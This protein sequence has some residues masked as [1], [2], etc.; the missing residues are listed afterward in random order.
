LLYPDG[1]P[2]F[3]IPV[4]YPPSK[5]IQSERKTIKEAGDHLAHIDAQNAN[6]P[7]R[8][9]RIPVDVTR[10]LGGKFGRSASTLGDIE[11]TTAAQAGQSREGLLDER[12][13]KLDVDADPDLVDWYCSG[14]SSCSL[15]RPTVPWDSVSHLCCPFDSAYRPP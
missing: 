3:E 8:L 6:R 7:T 14:E 4:R 15:D 9:G 10:K 11:L 12:A 1:E 2:G 5:R 13:S